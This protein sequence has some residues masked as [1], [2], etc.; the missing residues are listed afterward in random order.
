MNRKLAAIAIASVSVLGIL[1][2]SLVWLVKYEP[3]F[4]E[5]ALA[6]TAPPEIRRKQAKV[7]VQTTS[8]LVDGI[9]YEDS[10]SHAFSE[11][12]VNGWLAEELPA[13]YGEWL[14]PEVAAP[15]VKFEK[16][17]LLL[18]FQLRHGMWKGV[19][20]AIVRPWVAAPNQLALEIQSARIGLIPIPVDELL[21]DFVKHMNTAGLR[22]QWK[23]S[24][25]QDVLVVEFD[26][27]FSPDGDSGEH[28]VLEAVELEPELL[29]I[30]GQRSSAAVDS[31]RI[32]DKPTAR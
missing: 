18:A 1:A 32:A 21:G 4:Y 25:K 11:E 2:A 26:D 8:D 13:K 19:V 10:W 23:S 30:S 17:K 15:R 22:I 12:S 9:R 27:D 5:V 16:G 24:G 29:R 6:D 20:S 14:P 31:P 28:A 7:F 3:T